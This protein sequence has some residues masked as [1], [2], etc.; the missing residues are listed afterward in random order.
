MPIVRNC[1]GVLT[2]TASTNLIQIHERTPQQRSYLDLIF[3]LG[4]W[5]HDL[6]SGDVNISP[7]LFTVLL[8]DLA[9]LSNCFLLQRK[10]TY[11]I[12][13]SQV[14]E[15]PVELYYRFIINYIIVYTQNSDHGSEVLIIA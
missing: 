11:L 1:L 13:W 2:T 10:K 7:L 9:V 12:G 4:K 15:C 5:Q 14:T 3:I 8:F 6:G